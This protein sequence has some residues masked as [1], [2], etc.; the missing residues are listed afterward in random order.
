[1]LT[2]ICTHP[3]DPSVNSLL[4]QPEQ[5]MQ[6]FDGGGGGGEGSHTL[7]QIGVHPSVTSMNPPLES[8]LLT[9][10]QP[11]QERQLFCAGGGGGGGGGHT[12]TQVGTHPVDGSLSDPLQP[13]Q[14]VQS[15]GSGSGCG[16]HLSTHSQRGSDPS[17]PLFPTFFSSSSQVHSTQSVGSKR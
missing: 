1:M 13:V 11:V 15:V 6:S 10:W 9:N 7:T 8:P 4:S 12:L 16:A 3:S 5:T 14:T 17:D 2:Q